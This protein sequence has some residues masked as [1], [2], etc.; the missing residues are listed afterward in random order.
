MILQ[1]DTLGIAPL[2]YFHIFFDTSHE[3]IVNLSTQSSDNGKFKL[4][5]LLAIVSLSSR[6]LISVQV[7]S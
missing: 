6:L 4:Q 3:K 1:G 2:C 5:F 7:I